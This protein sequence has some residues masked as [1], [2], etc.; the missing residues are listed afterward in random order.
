MICWR[1]SDF[2]DLNG[3]GGR[4]IGGRWHTQGRPIVYLSEHPALALLEHLVHLE[5][6][7]E[8]LPD[9]YQLLEVEIPDNVPTGSVSD[10]GLSQRDA[11]WRSNVALT[12]S[13][14]DAWLTDAQALIYRVPSVILPRSTNVLFNPAHSDAH[15]A[16][17]VSSTNP[18]YDP[19]LFPDGT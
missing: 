19:R 15:R 2:A 6:E 16:R 1:I 10:D 18:P 3:E 14:G 11:N 4:L 7:L 13:V 12:C 9:S 17:I 5:I 8:D